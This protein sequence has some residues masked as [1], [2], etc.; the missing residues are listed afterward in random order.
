MNRLLGL[1]PGRFF[2]GGRLA[3]VWWAHKRHLKGSLEEP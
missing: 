1:S 2:F 3:D